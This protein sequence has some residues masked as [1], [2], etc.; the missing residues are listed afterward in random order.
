M[1][2]SRRQLLIGVASYFALP[3]LPVWASRLEYNLKAIGVAENSYMI[4]G[5]REYFTMENGGDIVNVGFI[6]TEDGIVLID[7]GPSSQYAMTLKKLI[8]KITGKDVI[9][10]YNTHFH[11]DHCFGNDAFNPNLIAAL[12]ETISGLKD[13]GENF[14]DN[15][16]R[17]L[18][19]WMRGTKLT[20]PGK[21]IETSMEKFGSHRLE[22][23]PLSGHSDA[24]LAIYDHKT[25]VIYSG[26]LCYLD[27][28]PGTPHA[29][30][31]EWHRSLQELRKIPYKMIMPGHGPADYNN[32]SIDQTDHYLT[33]LEQELVKSVKSGKDMMEAAQMP[34]PA[35]FQ[36]IDV[37]HGEIERSVAHFYPALEE[38]WLPDIIE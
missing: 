11:P 7:T 31:T 24:D 3:V 34:I 36:S 10:V 15:L 8:T 23:I 13:Q 35:E 28:A 26:D 17:M 21:P 29:N 37:I 12:P 30:L 33:W 27:R 25:G 20:L 9:R 2:K 5:K 32:R 14:R 19:D 16:Y 1:E 6:D 4:M 18:G 38:K 22:M